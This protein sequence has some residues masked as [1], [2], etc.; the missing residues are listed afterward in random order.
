MTV[1][2]KK[3]MNFCDYK[4]SLGEV[5]KGVHA[6]RL[7][8]FAIRDVAATIGIGIVLALLWGGVFWMWMGLKMLSWENVAIYWGGLI[9]F[10]VIAAFL[11]GIYMHWL[12]CVETTLNKMLGLA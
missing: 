2:K 4:D 9:L 3:K 10:W 11:F 1:I 6:Q 8:G 7:G 12:F 5:G